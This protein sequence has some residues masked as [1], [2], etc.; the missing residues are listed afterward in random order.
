MNILKVFKS[1]KGFTPI[2]AKTF[3]NFIKK[4][5]GNQYIKNQI[6]SNRLVRIIHREFS[7]QSN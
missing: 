7:N 6:Q 5:T 3:T 1:T 4:N 2:I